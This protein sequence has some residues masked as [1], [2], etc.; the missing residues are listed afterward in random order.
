MNKTATKKLTAARPNTFT[1]PKIISPSY[2]TSI[3]LMAY[4]SARP[5][6]PRA[7]LSLASNFELE[8]RLLIARKLFNVPS[9]LFRQQLEGKA[10][11]NCFDA[12]CFPDMSIN[13]NKTQFQLYGDGFKKTFA[14]YFDGKTGLP[15]GKIDELTERYNSTS[16]GVISNMP[17]DYVYFG[18][19][20]RQLGS[21]INLAADKNL[22][23]VY[24]NSL[25]E[26]YK[27]TKP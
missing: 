15:M 25:V 11:Q 16:I 14:E 10:P 17:S 1:T 20:E 7:H 19:W 23:L 8:E 13:L 4:T 12:G 27:I 6:L 18:P 3:Y 2:V 21:R 24:R 22:S 26:I 5:F 9:D